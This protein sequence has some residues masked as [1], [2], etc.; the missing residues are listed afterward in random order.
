MVWQTATLI[1]L[2]AIFILG[3]ATAHAVTAKIWPAVFLFAV[4]AAGVGLTVLSTIERE[5]RQA[6][7]EAA[8][9]ILD[10]NPKER[11]E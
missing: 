1:K 7:F 2:S 10:A 9:K 3:G 11:T 6:A 8:R 5:R 4:I